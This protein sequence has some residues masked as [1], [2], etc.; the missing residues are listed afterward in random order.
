[1][2]LKKNI[3]TFLLF[4]DIIMLKAENDRLK[5]EV[6]KSKEIIRTMRLHFS[7]THICE[8]DALILEY[9]GLPNRK[10]YESLL[11]VLQDLDIKYYLERKVFVFYNTN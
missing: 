3:Y 6:E 8:N 7:Y 11:F 4:V 9:T 1:M 2:H 5:L 10:I